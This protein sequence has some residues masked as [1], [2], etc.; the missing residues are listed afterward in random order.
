MKRLNSVKI[1]LSLSV[2]FAIS[3]DAKSKLYTYN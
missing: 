3:V 2:A 1:Y